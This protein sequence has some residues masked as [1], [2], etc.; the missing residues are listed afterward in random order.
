VII[1]EPYLG[2]LRL[3]KSLLVSCAPEMIKLAN[4]NTSS[5]LGFSATIDSSR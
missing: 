3:C 1:S 2:G 4:L 5:L